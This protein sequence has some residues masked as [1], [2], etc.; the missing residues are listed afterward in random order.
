MTQGL[1]AHGLGFRR[2]G[3][4]ILDGISLSLG[5]GDMVAL[6][7]PNGAGKTSLIRI[8]L[9]LLPPQQGE[10]WLDGTPLTQWDRRAVARRLAYVPQ[11][12]R[13]VF[14]FSV[15]EIVA[16]GRVPVSGWTLRAADRPTIVEALDR[17]RAGHLAARAYTTLSGGEQQSVLIARALAQGARTLIL[18]EPAASLD[19]GQR[20]RLM[21]TLR[22]LAADGYAILA[23][24]HDIDE[25]RRAYPR[26]MVLTDGRMIAEGPA[27]AIL[28]PA[29]LAQAYGVPLPEH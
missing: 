4:Q 11:R 13:A 29:T 18:D 10:V 16:M 9:G 21:E 3:R 23:S 28:T 25:A 24:S 15:S 17:T 5:P 27:G 8:L 22:A 20:H 1:E 6:L 12:H 19:P 26:A 2:A 14:P 7:G